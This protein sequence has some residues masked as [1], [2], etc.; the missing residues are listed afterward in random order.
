MVFKHSHNL[1]TSGLPAR[2]FDTVSGTRCY[3]YHFFEFGMFK[4][5]NGLENKIDSRTEQKKAEQPIPGPLLP[6]IQ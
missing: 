6:A 5:L 4:S 3:V 1:G 2:N